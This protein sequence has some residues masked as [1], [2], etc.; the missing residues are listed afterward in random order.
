MIA[1]HPTKHE[2]QTFWE[3]EPLAFHTSPMPGFEEQGFSAAQ[4]ALLTQPTSAFWQDK[5]RPKDSALWAWAIENARNGVE[6]IDM[7][8][9]LGIPVAADTL[10]RLLLRSASSD[11]K[12]PKTAML[13][14]AQHSR[15][16]STEKD[17]TT[18]PEVLTSPKNIAHLTLLDFHPGVLQWKKASTGNGLLHSAVLYKSKATIA[19][20]LGK[21]ASQEPNNARVTPQEMAKEE[22][23]AWPATFGKSKAD[24]PASP[25]SPAAT[26]RERVKAKPADASGK[27]QLNLF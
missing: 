26:S 17:K 10:V 1:A 12:I 13:F 14:A 27:D 20:L 6:T 11:E 4:W 5:S 21:G 15:A 3:Q 19:A 24:L 16:W 18:A 8:A 23:V 7:M 22:M 2:L 25:T 9:R